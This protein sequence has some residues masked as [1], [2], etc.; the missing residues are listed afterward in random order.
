MNE[1]YC[2]IKQVQEIEKHE[3]LFDYTKK[4]YCNEKTKTRAWDIISAKV[5]ISGKIILFR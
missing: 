4:S 2:L 1:Y 3:C 5:N